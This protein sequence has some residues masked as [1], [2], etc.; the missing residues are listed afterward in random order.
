MAVG[1][2]D[3]PR[4]LEHRDG[5]VSRHDLGNIDKVL[6]LSFPR[7]K[8]FYLREGEEIELVQDE[9]VDDRSGAASVQILGRLV[10][11][12]KGY[13]LGDR[14]T[15]SGSEFTEIAMGCYFFGQQL[16]DALPTEASQK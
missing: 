2:P 9:R 1:N 8:L 3:R 7:M 11:R 12:T 5:I 16:A 4:N 6:R 13:R 15:F 14:V 10:T